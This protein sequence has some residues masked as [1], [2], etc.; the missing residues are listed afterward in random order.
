MKNKSET[1]YYYTIPA[2]VTSVKFENIKLYITLYLYK[3]HK[4]IG[5]INIKLI[6]ELYFFCVI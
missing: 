3:A 2:L 5:Y 1:V 4:K 6:N